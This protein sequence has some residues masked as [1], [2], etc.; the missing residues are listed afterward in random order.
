MT[1]L[2]RLERTRAWPF[3]VGCCDQRGGQAWVK[4]P[5]YSEQMIVHWSDWSS[6]CSV[7][8]LSDHPRQLLIRARSRTLHVDESVVTSQATVLLCLRT[9]EE[10]SLVE[11]E[12]AMLAQRW[13]L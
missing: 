13:A 10:H 6:S 4:V 9:P 2:I 8:L 7:W 5:G 11:G 12:E 3:W 1:V